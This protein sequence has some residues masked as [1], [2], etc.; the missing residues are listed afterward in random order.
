[1]TKVILLIAGTVV[2]I[3]L[4]YTLLPSGKYEKFSKHI[5]GLILI[6]VFAGTI[7]KVDISSDILNFDED[8]P[9]YNN[10]KISEVIGL[11]TARIIES[12]ITEKLSSEGVTIKDVKVTLENN[13]ISMVSIK[14]YNFDA[15]EKIRDIVSSFCDIKKD[16]VV[17]E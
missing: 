5:F 7:V 15:S 6:L 3:N 16:N 12:K 1:M 14:K 4:V 8:V 13:K 17:I 10:K 11:Q 2:A 9:V